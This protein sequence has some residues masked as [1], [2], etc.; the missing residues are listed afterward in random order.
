MQQVIRRLKHLFKQMVA[1][2]A[3]STPEDRQALWR[4]VG[5]LRR[6]IVRITATSQL[7]TGQ[8]AARQRTCE[9]W[10][11]H[12]GRKL[13]SPGSVV[14]A[15]RHRLEGQYGAGR[16]GTPGPHDILARAA[17]VTAAVGLGGG[18]RRGIPLA[19]RLGQRLRWLATCRGKS[20][21]WK[22]GGAGMRALARDG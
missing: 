9:R 7:L 3:V 10:P 21:S 20:K 5:K 18:P 22:S 19:R 6:R 17:S 12:R 1:M 8:T 15:L 13:T 16:A 11:A 14:Q 2:A 4:R